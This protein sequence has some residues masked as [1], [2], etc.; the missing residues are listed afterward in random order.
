MY[1]LCRKGLALSEYNFTF[2]F[3]RLVIEKFGFKVRLRN[4]CDAEASSLKLRYHL[5]FDLPLCD[6][7]LPTV[8]L[9]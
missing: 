8:F 4:A 2:K 5:S 3:C 6:K 1:I 9:F 7:L